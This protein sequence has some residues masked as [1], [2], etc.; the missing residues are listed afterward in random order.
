MLNARRLF[1]RSI[2]LRLASGCAGT[3]ISRNKY[4][5]PTVDGNFHLLVR[6]RCIGHFACLTGTRDANA[7]F[8]LVNI[9]HH[10]PRIVGLDVCHWLKLSQLCDRG[11][12]FHQCFSFIGEPTHVWLLK[13]LGHELVYRRFAN[14]LAVSIIGNLNLEGICCCDICHWQP[15]RTASVLR[16]IILLATIRESTHNVLFFSGVPEK[17]GVQCIVRKICVV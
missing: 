12:S 8:H 6:I 9:V 5:S 7:A 1:Q 3:A 4:G 10:V 16:L 15:Q 13:G 14:R 11:G 17:V 2:T